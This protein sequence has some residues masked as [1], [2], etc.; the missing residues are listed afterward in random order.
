MMDLVS[1]SC[2]EK[3]RFE[4]NKLNGVLAEIIAIQDF[5]SNGFQIRRTGTGSDFIAFK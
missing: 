1:I 3:T 2:P 4:E 5:R